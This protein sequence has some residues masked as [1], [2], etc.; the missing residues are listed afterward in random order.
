M[1]SKGAG[2]E[3][4]PFDLLARVVAA[5]ATGAGPFDRLAVDDRGGGPVG[6]ALLLSHLLPQGVEDAFP[7]AGP[8]P[9]VEVM[10]DGAFRGE[11]VGQGP[12]GTAVLVDGEDGVDHL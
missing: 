12:P 7:D 5:Q 6:L 3:S 4:R 9:A 10:P 11:V 2:G 1:N 8:S